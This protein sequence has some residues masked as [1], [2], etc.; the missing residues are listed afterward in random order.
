MRRKPMSSSVIKPWR[1]RFSIISLVLLS[2]AVLFSLIVFVVDSVFPDTRGY[3]A[4][5]VFGLYIFGSIPIAVLLVGLNF[6]YPA[7]WVKWWTMSIAAGVILV[8]GVP[9]VVVNYL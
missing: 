3:A 4:F 1:K 2:L 5:V 7:K 6:I 8:I 9:F